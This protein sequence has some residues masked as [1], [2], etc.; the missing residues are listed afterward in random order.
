[1]SENEENSLKLDNRK[2]AEEN[3]LYTGNLPVKIR[4]ISANFE[5][6]S[7]CSV[8]PVR[9]WFDTSTSQADGS[10]VDGT[11]HGRPVRTWAKVIFNHHKGCITN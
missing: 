3:F 11:T 7:P 10:M 8:G 9:P 2:I 4:G 1:M 5:A 6:S